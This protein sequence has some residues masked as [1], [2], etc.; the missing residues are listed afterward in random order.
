MLKKFFVYIIITLI[1]IQV[2]LIVSLSIS[3]EAAAKLKKYQKRMGRITK[4]LKMTEKTTSFFKDKM[5]AFKSD[6]GVDITEHLE[7]ISSLVKEKDEDLGDALHVINQV[8]QVLYFSIGLV[9]FFLLLLLLIDPR[10]FI[11]N[12]G[13][14]LLV[15]GIFCL[16]N[17][18][19]VHFVFVI[20]FDEVFKYL[21]DQA[22][23]SASVPGIP[24]LPAIDILPIKGI[25]ILPSLINIPIVP[26]L[27][28]SF[29]KD[30]VAQLVSIVFTRNLM[31]GA[32]TVVS[33]FV[34]KII[35]SKFI[36]NRNY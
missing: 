5:P 35:G 23:I 29:S 7:G 14:T 31:A 9:L 16:L 6:D 13:I 15:S 36:R 30:F 17:A 18:A 21:Y 28:K 2:P 33:G 19:A 12:F 34:L 25:P 10:A 8:K 24:I 4:P 1:S 22:N 11:K 3:Q 20:N 32:I 26:A 27:I